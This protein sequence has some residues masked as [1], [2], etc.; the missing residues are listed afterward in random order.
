MSRWLLSA[1]CI[2]F[3]FFVERWVLSILFL[4]LGYEYI[5]TLRL[6]HL[7]SQSTDLLPKA[8][9]ARDGGFIDGIHFQDFARYSLL[10][11]SNLVSG[12]LL[13]T[14]RKPS[15]Y[16]TRAQEVVVPFVATFFY[17]IFNQRMPLPFWMTT[18]LVPA[19][20][21]ARLAA[22]GLVLST[23]GIFASLACIL[24]L[25]RSLGIVVSV[26][27]IVLAGPYRYVRHPIYLSYALLFT[28]LFLTACTVRMGILVTGAY[29]MLCWRARLEE[30]VLSAH[31]AAY[32]EWMTRTG[33]LFP[34]WPA[35]RHPVPIVVPARPVLLVPRRTVLIP[36]RVMD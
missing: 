14:A 1:P 19:V 17:L 33:F 29:A 12:V 34:R 3:V 16:P 2:R 28:G 32:R 13:L 18:P 27:R 4:Y 11:L 24:W 8:M 35:R 9:V 36:V 26:R 10:A 7:F 23:L 22:A 20:W 30:K 25:G 21:G 15:R 6:L 31:S 5:D